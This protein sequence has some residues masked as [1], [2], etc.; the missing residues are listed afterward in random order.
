MRV[1]TFFAL[2]LVALGMLVITEPSVTC[3]PYEVGPNTTVQLNDPVMT[4]IVNLDRVLFNYFS[5]EQ[6]IRKYVREKLLDIMHRIFAQ[7]RDNMTN[8]L[9]TP[10]YFPEGDTASSAYPAGPTPANPWARTSIIDI[11]AELGL[12]FAPGIYQQITDYNTRNP[13]HKIPPFVWCFS[14]RAAPHL[15]TS[16]KIFLAMQKGTHNLDSDVRPFDS[17][18]EGSWPRPLAPRQAP[19]A[20]QGTIGPTGR[21]FQ[22]PVSIQESDSRVG[23]V[24]NNNNH[25]YHH[26]H[27][28]SH[29]SHHSHHI[30]EEVIDRV[31][32]NRSGLY[33][34]VLRYHDD[35]HW[36]YCA[37]EDWRNT[38]PSYHQWDGGE[39]FTMHMMEAFL[40]S[41][42]RWLEGFRVGH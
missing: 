12:K 37:P 32:F 5:L 21:L 4:P 9:D 35:D 18:L 14:S 24:S 7:P 22:Y 34:G 11:Q 36:H 1:L 39:N 15:Y 41:L 16:D 13:S 8:P 20:P 17:A 2:L 10:L 40:G 27:H 23:P 30:A 31:I 29:H 28:H 6:E 42:E 33:T 26:H 19:M 3:S 38:S 25:P